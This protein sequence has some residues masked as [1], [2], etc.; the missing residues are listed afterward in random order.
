MIISAN[1]IALYKRPLY[2]MAMPMASKIANRSASSPKH[3]HRNIYQGASKNNGHHPSCINLKRNIGTLSAIHSLSNNS[4]CILHRN[5]SI[6]F[7]KV[8]NTARYNDKH[9]HDKQSFQRVHR[10]QLYATICGKRATIPAKISIELPL[11]IPNK[12]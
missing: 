6:T 12:R 9:C 4:S 11:P 8:Y 10:E 5:L 7:F 3:K 2:C 1:S